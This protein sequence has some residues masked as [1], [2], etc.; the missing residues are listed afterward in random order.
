LFILSHVT[1]TAPRRQPQSQS[2]SPEERAHSTHQ[3]ARM[4]L[5]GIQALFGFQLIAA[6][7]T[8]FT[9]LETPDRVV[10]LLSLV[11]VAVAIALI[12]TPAAYHRICEPGR[13]S[14]F[15][16]RL[17]SALVAAAMVPLLLGISLDIYVVTRLS[18]PSDD[19]WLALVLGL[20]AFILFFALWI[21]FPYWQLQHPHRRPRSVWLR[22]WLS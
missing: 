16:T 12:M 6:F 18:L 21:V 2:E 11:L 19:P 15:F 10:H 3:E 13:T 7:N 1:V 5:P 14:M 20:M 22:R 8:R 4:V 9:E 17:A